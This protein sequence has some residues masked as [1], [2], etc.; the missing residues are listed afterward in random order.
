MMNWSSQASGML[1]PGDQTATRLAATASHINASASP[2]ANTYDLIC[3]CTDMEGGSWH[4][5]G[6]CH[7]DRDRTVSLRRRDGYKN[8]LK[9]FQRQCID[10][11]SYHPFVYYIASRIS[12]SKPR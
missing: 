1:D 9:V 8:G 3:S 10:L 12:L 5:K 7:D 11:F 4:G 2:Y 6:A